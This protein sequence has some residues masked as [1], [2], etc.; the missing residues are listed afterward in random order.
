[1]GLRAK[2]SPDTSTLSDV[3]ERV[4]A[5]LRDDGIAVVPFA[6]LFG[7][8]STWTELEQDISQFVADA[9]HQVQTFGPDELKE[10]HGKSY[11]IRRFRKPKGAEGPKRRKLT[12]DNAWVSLGTSPEILGVVNEYRGR[13]M[14]LHDVDNWYTVPYADAEER[15]ASQRWHRDGWENHIVKVF[16][17]FSDV[18]DEAGP[19]EYVRSSAAGGRYGSL[20]PWAEEEVYVPQDEF[21]A[22]VADEDVLS[23]TGT[24]G[25]IIFCDTSGFHRGGFARTKPRILSYHTYLSEDA[26]QVRKRIFTVDWQD[27]GAE[28]A[29]AARYA[30]AS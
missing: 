24:P 8:A 22:T 19:L 26:Q 1:V 15:V 7:D 4:V 2:P 6:E 16:I 10:I 28:L 30:L 23:L 13:M 12:P 17:Y 18:D 21:A 3:Q 20:W 11:L 27:D 14:R 9:E 25:T 5:A 29:P